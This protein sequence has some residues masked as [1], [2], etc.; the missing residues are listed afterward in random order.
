MAEWKL[1]DKDGNQVKEGDEI[2][3]F[4]EDL[5]K[6]VGIYP[7]GRSGGMSGKIQVQPLKGGMSKLLFPQVF[8][9]RFVEID[10]R[11]IAH[12]DAPTFAQEIDDLTPGTRSYN[13]A[14]AKEKGYDE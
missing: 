3:D 7:P 9:C 8:K 4:R 11:Q 6:V 1:F 10:D 12:G 14:M 5:H 2:A 13:R